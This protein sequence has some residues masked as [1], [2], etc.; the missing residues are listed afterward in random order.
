MHADLVRPPSVD[1]HLQQGELPEVRIDPLLHRV[2]RDRFSS[3]RTFRGHSCTSHRVP[4]D[5]A[6]DRPA[7]LL[8]PAMHQRDI[9]F[10]DYAT[11]KLSRQLSMGLVVLGHDNEPARSLIQP[12]YNPGPQRV[13]HARKSSKA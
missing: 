2:V 9:S 10:L 12:V 6:A 1:S 13:A 5:A 8:H 11:R 3:A 4:A 7:I